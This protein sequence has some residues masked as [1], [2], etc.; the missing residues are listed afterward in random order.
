MRSYI[1]AV[2]FDGTVVDDAYPKIGKEKLFAFES[3]KQLMA[4][5]HRLVLWTYRSGKELQDAVEFCR[6]NGVEFYAV[7]SSF[8]G[9]IFDQEK[10]SRKINADIFI[11]DRNLGGFPGW[12]ETLQVI[13][14]KIEFTINAHG[15]EKKKKKKGFF[16]L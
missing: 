5:G 4:K 14:N 13:S 2:D 16:G 11:D 15:V 6:E 7:N 12:G 3:L 8:E 10:Q 9:E 1:I